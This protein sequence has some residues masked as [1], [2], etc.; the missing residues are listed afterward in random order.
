MS[1]EAADRE[2]RSAPAHATRMDRPLPEPASRP[3]PGGSRQAGKTLLLSVAAANA[4]AQ[5]GT[6]AVDQAVASLV[7]I[8]IG[9]IG[10]GAPVA[11]Y[12]LKGN[13][14]RRS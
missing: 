6:N 10:L 9:T 8:A 11:I 5:T 4:I 1:V 3:G 2:A 13:G 14:R 12:Y 7:F